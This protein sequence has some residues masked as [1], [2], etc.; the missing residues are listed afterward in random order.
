MYVSTY[1][2]IPFTLSKALGMGSN[3]VGNF[4]T[5]MASIKTEESNKFFSC[6]WFQP[7]LGRFLK[8]LQTMNFASAELGVCNKISN[9]IV[10]TFRIHNLKIDLR[11]S[12]W[13]VWLLKKSGQKKLLR[14]QSSWSIRDLTNESLKLISKKPL[15]K[16]LS[17]NDKTFVPRNL[18][19]MRVKNPQIFL[20]LI[21]YLF[22]LNNL[23]LIF[24][25]CYISTAFQRQIFFNTKI[26]NW[27]S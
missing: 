5:F 15:F 13:K 4:S 8:R 18:K 9:F 27:S 16:F 19:F 21:K 11:T 22:L 20:L 2:A 3:K 7:Y 6:N 23:I 1:L 25:F 17:L 10:D 14:S 26:A 12:F 24:F